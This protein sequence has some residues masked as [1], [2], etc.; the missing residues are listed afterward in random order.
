MRNNS[1]SFSMLY[2]ACAACAVLGVV[3]C[4]G[5]RGMVAVNG[6]LA[7][8][9]A[10]NPND[11]DGDGYGPEDGDC[12][13]GN[14]AI[15][16]MAFEIAGNGIDDDCDGTVDET[17][18]PCDGSTLGNKT[19]ADLAAALGLCEPRFL[20][21]AEMK[22][23]SDVRA[24]DII[25]TFGPFAHVEGAGMV[26][27]STGIAGDAKSPQY[28]RPQT[29][30]ILGAD[31]T[32]INPDFTVPG[33]S[34]CGSSQ[35]DMV[36]DYSELSLTLKVPQNANSLSFQ[37]HF[38]S[39]EFPEYVCT[40]YNDEFLVEMS[41]K[42]SGTGFAN[43]SFDAAKN[44][45]TINNSFFTICQNDA[46]KPQTQHCA[47]SV[48]GLHGTGYDDVL[49]GKPIGGSTGWLSTKTP[50]IPG[51]EITLRF[52]VFD[53][54]DHIYDSAVLIDAFTWSTEVILSSVTV[55]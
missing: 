8:V 49:L 48:D 55:Q 46:G 31:N 18:P 13:D 51:D 4:D 32:A 12:N 52:I 10:P 29:G 25:S 53:E 42:K 22:G 39:A 37:F 7:G 2:L 24:R 11:H 44:P 6:D 5:G 3:A 17:V 27:F 35:P 23:P 34:T 9:A 20:T 40:A 43:V 38:F 15:G 36:N 47:K 41:S 1:K 21:H 30:T 14:P 45:I 33:I 16:P 19:A 26:V 50:T 28:V 54:G